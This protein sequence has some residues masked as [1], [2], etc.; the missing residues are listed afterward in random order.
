VDLYKAGVY[1]YAQSPDFEIL[2]WGY[3][4]NEGPV[5]VIDLASGE[6][7]PADVVAALW[8]PEIEKWS[9]NVA[10]ERVC[11]QAWLYKH[12]YPAKLDPENWFCSMIWSATLGLPM[13][14]KGVGAILGLEK[15]KLDAG[16]DLIR[17][18]C[19]PCKPTKTNSQRTRNLP[20]DDPEKWEL[21][22]AYNKR[23]VETECLIQQKLSAFPVP[24]QIWDDFWL[25]QRINDRGIRIDLTFVKA[26]I[27]L[28]GCCKEELITQMKNLTDLENPNSVVQ[29]K[30]WLSEHGVEVESL[31]KKDVAAL[32][33]DAPDEIAD[34]LSLRLQL[35]K[36]SIR[37]YE[38]MSASCCKDFRA[39]GM[40]QFYGASRTGRFSGR[41]IQLQNLP[42]NHLPDLKQA[43]N[44]VADRNLE[45]LQMLYEDVP[46]TLSQLIRTAFIPAAGKKFIVA[47]FSAIEARVLAWL[48]GEEW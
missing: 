45:A 43:R 7:P 38:A 32:I 27:D 40:F 9:F 4:W 18:F 46:D 23:D 6:R 25:D 11:L 41:I 29:L 3:S 15:Q 34:I 22:K 2:L 10:F 20:F 36:S 44:L 48:A 12:S 14:L 17:Y 13:S 39:H 26:A 24:Q 1:K 8:N 5:T 28:D 31:G 37:K 33:K 35:A 16:R 19:K 21:F 42:Q 47:D 30:A